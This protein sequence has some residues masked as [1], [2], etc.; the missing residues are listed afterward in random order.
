M[1]AGEPLNREVIDQVR[2]AWGITI[3]R[4]ELRHAEQERGS[5]PANRNPRE[6]WEDDFPNLKT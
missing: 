1:A 3:R 6:W 4:V 5:D 2:R